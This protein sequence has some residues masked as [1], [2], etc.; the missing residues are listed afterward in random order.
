[1]HHIEIKR[2]MGEADIA[3]I[4]ELLHAAALADGHLPLGEHQ[5]LDLVQGGREGFAGFVAKAGHHPHPVGYAQVSRGPN[6]WAVEFVIDPHHRD[7]DDNIGTDL[8][9]AALA[10]V[11]RCGGGHV[12]LWV[13]KPTPSNDFIATANGLVKGRDLHQMRRRLP[14]DAAG[15]PLATRQFVPGQDEAA[16]LKV[17]NRAFSSHPEQGGWDLTT[18]A[19][20]E[21]E[22]WFDPAGFLLLEQGGRLA[23]FCW[24]KVHAESEPAIGEIYVIATDP[25]FAGLGLG[26]GLVE[27]GLTYLYEAGLKTAML[28]VD[29][30]NARAH[31]L[32]ARMG[33]VVDHI[34]RAYVGDVAPAV[35]PPSPLRDPLTPN[36][37]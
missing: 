26:R 5:W 15:A 11:A 37:S 30:D 24:T 32:Y 10:E 16:W 1:M 18:L 8:L 4:S 25:D 29:A 33:F 7:S 22:P 12:H 2:R 17:N 9:G 3:S 27:A 13:P 35:T 36:N 21:Q 28:Y 19:H 31:G 23:G 34:D 6:S 20:R 14:I